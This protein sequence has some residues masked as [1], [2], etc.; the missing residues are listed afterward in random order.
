MM[1]V[2]A[3]CLFVVCCVQSA[4][5]SV[6]PS[7]YNVEVGQSFT[8]DVG[9]DSVADLYACQFDL[10][11]DPGLL[12]ASAIAEGAFL[13]LG[14]PTFFLAGTIDNVDG[15]I[16]STADSLEGPVSG[17]TGT[18]VLASA[19]F[20][21][22]A[23]G[24]TSIEI[25]NTFLIDSQSDFIYA[26]TGDGTINVVATPEPVSFGL[27]LLALASLAA[28]GTVSSWTHGGQF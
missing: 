22:L 3:S 27:L 8:V 23:P 19:T 26:T 25:A 9:I 13:G 5:I 24:T 16:L 10:A 21:A 11:F 18:G 4:T 1:R 14:G 20:T 28:F 12:S 15:L 2:L 7:P 6:S 17:V